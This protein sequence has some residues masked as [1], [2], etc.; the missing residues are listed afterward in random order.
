MDSDSDFL[1]LSEDSDI[2][3]AYGID[4]EEIEEMVV[5]LAPF[6]EELLKEFVQQGGGNKPPEMAE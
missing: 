3:E 1:F 6:A 2:E 5:R 4:C